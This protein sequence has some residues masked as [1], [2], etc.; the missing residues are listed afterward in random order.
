[1]TP[2]ALLPYCGS[3]IHA[4]IVSRAS[5]TEVLALATARTRSISASSPLVGVDEP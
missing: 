4:R 1:M 5:P 2:A 3:P